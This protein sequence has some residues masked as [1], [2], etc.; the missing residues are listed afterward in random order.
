MAEHHITLSWS[1]GETP[2]TY[3]AYSRNHSI[4]FKNGAPIA[5]SAA[6]TYRGD[7]GKGDPEDM[8][9]AALSSCHMLSFLAIA[10]KK[11][12]T[13]DLY[14]DD[15][16]G[17]LEQE[18]GRLW[19][20]RVILRPRIVSDADAAMLAEIHHLAHQACFI[21]NSVKTE[22]QVEPR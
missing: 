18:G 17:F 14:H 15:A 21:A 22:I 5:F 2:F 19:M 13:V 6:P 7:A 1:R 16:V 3:D 10:A 8:L 4:T 20:T 12:V 9:V 11:K